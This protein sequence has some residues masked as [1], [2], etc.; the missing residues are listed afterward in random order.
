MCQF[1]S[2]LLTPTSR[3]SRYFTTETRKWP[4]NSSRTAKVWIPIRLMTEFTFPHIR[5][6][7]WEPGEWVSV[8]SSKLSFHYWS[9]K[10]ENEVPGIIFWTSLLL[11]MWWF[12]QELHLMGNA[13]RL[14]CRKCFRDNSVILFALRFGFKAFLYCFRAKKP[15]QLASR[16]VKFCF[17]LWRHRTS[18]YMVSGP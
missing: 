15:K 4:L 9:G 14:L 1:N 2:L 16:F 13:T 12:L 18:Q 10:N 7:W 3:T 5:I 6:R 11:V 8:F 17:F